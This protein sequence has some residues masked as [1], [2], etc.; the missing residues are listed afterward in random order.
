MTGSIDTGV[1]FFPDRPA[2]EL[3]A[4]IEEA[5]RCGLNEVWLGDEGPARE[6]MTVLA[7]AAVATSTIRLGVGITNPYV[8]HPAVAVASAATIAELAPGRVVLGVG[9]GGAMSLGPFQLDAER[10][11]AAVERFLDIAEASAA[12]EPTEGYT[13]SDLAVAAVVPALP[14]F[15]GARGPMLNALASR[16]ATGVF[17][18]G[19]PPFRYTEVIG[20]ARSTNRIDVALYPSVAFDEA[21]RERHRPEMIWSLFDAPAHVMADFDL[22]ADQIAAAAEALRRGD[23]VPAMQLIDDALLDQLMMIGAPE[24]VGRRL[25]EL[26]LEHDPTSIGVAIVSDELGR[27]IGQAATAFDQM[28][29]VLN[30][31]GD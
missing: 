22:D 23:R 6:P 15:V 2:T 17:V 8:R 4:A 14:I 11:L 30:E 7:A 3:V 28:H 16:R 21:A 1:W 13:P 9:A 19:V 12:G 10:P 20:W 29:I 27:S 25:A 18:A 24:V 26:V 5:E 31:R